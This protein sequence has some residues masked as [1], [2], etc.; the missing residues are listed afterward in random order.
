MAKRVCLEC[1]AIGSWPRGRCPKHAPTEAQRGYDR[2]YLATRRSWQ[3]R[4]DAGERVTCWRCSDPID[5]EHWHLGHDDVDRDV[6][7]GPECPSCN[8]TAAGRNSHMS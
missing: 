2:D 3:R 4:M 5:P 8:L 6:V 1:P 7:R